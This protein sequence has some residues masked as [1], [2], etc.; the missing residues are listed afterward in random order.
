MERTSRSS[1]ATSEF[2]LG[3]VKTLTCNLRVECLDFVDAETNCTGNFCRKKAIEKTILCIFG[4]I[5]FSHSLDPERTWLAGSTC[6]FD[7]PFQMLICVPIST[8][9]PDGI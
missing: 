9:R 3:C 2:D 4:S 7:T 6:L 5:A 8:A 1:P